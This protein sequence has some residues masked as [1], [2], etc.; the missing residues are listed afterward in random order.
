MPLVVALY[1]LWLYVP[2][3]VSSVVSFV[4][5]SVVSSVVS[6]VVPSDELAAL[7]D[8]FF[9]DVVPVDPVFPVV[10]LED[11]FSEVVLADELCV[12]VVDDSL[13]LSFEEE[14]LLSEDFFD[15]SE[16]FFLLSSLA[17]SSNH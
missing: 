1:V 6:F 11:S 9:L 12:S 15:E 13:L 3:P 10:P 8:V 2:D 14:S 7:D 16:S 17:F 5:L 4:V